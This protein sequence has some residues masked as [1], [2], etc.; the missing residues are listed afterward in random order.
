MARSLSPALAERP[1][2][3]QAEPTGPSAVEQELA[4]RLNER[5]TEKG[6]NYDR[7][8]ARLEMRGEHDAAKVLRQASARLKALTSNAKAVLAS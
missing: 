1:L 2:F 7:A 5:L 4:R 8:A 6:E 3:G